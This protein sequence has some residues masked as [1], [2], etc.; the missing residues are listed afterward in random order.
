MNKQEPFIITL[1]RE[2]GSGGHTVGSILAEKLNVRYCDKQLLGSLEKQF[3]LTSSGIEKLKGEKKNWLADFV[4]RVSP[5]PSARALGLNPMYTQEFAFDVT[6]DD[7]YKAEV[8]IL[9]G[10][11]DMGSCVIAGRS[12]FFIFKDHP[13]T[14]NIFITASMP[15]R[16]ERIMRKQG[17]SE[18]SA[19]AVI[20]SIDQGRDNYIQ[21]YAGVSRFDARNYDIVLKA[22]GHTEEQLADIVLSYI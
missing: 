13:N 8:E 1:S 14:L 11:A 16:I 18:D 12:G 2:V 6:T 4:K 15:H 19:K 17:L 21:R 7:I 5:M 22:D 3:N 9:R 20:Q 10:F